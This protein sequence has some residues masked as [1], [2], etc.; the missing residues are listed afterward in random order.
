MLPAFLGLITFRWSM[1]TFAWALAA[2]L[3]LGAL[4][5]LYWVGRL[6]LPGTLRGI[7]PGPATAAAVGW[8]AAFATGWSM[9]QASPGLRAAVGGSLRL[10]W[11]VVPGLFPSVLGEPPI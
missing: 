10:G 1:V 5:S 9:P 3:T 6:L 2:P 11:A 7:L 8:A 4:A